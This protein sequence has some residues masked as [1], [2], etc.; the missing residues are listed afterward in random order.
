MILL[1]RPL[2]PLRKGALWKNEEKPL[3][4]SDIL[5]GCLGLMF[6]ILSFRTNGEGTCV[7]FNYFIPGG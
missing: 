3:M 1:S 7:P 2:S 5:C 4:L 6:R